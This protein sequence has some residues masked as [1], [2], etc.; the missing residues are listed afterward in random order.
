MTGQALTD[1]TK[2]QLMVDAMNRMGYTAMALGD[3]EMSLGVEQLQARLKEAKFPFLSANVQVKATNALFA[4]PY[5][6][7]DLNGLKVG[8]LGLTAE[9][10]AKVTINA[11]GTTVPSAAG[12]FVVTD[13][14]AAA[15]K[16]VPELKAKANLVIVLSNLGLDAEEKLAEKVPGI[17]AIVGGGT[18]NILTPPITAGESVIVEAGYDGEFLGTLQ[19]KLDAQGAVNRYEGKVPALEPSFADDPDMAKWLEAAKQKAK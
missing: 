12:E 11:I 3:R 16:Y 9:N 19:L 14:V 15:Q 1:L 2:G 7:V 5:T 4:Q 8:I 6:I 13:P 18:R 17:A 10:A